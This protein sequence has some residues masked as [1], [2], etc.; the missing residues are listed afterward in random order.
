MAIKEKSD[1]GD[2]SREMDRDPNGR[3]PHHGLR[4][5]QTELKMV[6]RHIREREELVKR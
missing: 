3:R 4:E 1:L 2:S 6:Q 5:R